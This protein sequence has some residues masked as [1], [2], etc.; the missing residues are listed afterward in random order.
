MRATAYQAQPE[1]SAAIEL[2]ELVVTGPLRKVESNADG[3]WTV[4]PV[5][6]RPL[7]L[8]GPAEVSA[9][10]QQAQ[11]TGPKALAPAPAAG[12]PA[13]EAG[14]GC[15][16]TTRTGTGSQHADVMQARAVHGHLSEWVPADRRAAGWDADAGAAAVRIH[17]T[18]GLYV[19]FV[20]PIG[21]A[22]PIYLAGRRD[23]ALDARRVP[24]TRDS[25]VATLLAAYL[26]DR[27][28]L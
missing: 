1:G 11:G 16:P 24:G 10:V 18:H 22:F 3:S 25:L 6:G 23:G 7:I 14:C 2:F 4:T 5:I 21:R 9:Y 19:M 13:V 27:G 8:T 17:S 28:E 15:V 20:P 12:L 26:R